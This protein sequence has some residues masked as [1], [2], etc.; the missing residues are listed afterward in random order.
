MHVEDGFLRKVHYSALFG[1]GKRQEKLSTQKRREKIR[2]CGERK[3]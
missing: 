1:R 3:Q 2:E